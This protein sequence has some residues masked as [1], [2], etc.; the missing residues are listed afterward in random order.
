MFHFTL[1]EVLTKQKNHDPVLFQRRVRANPQQREGV[2]LICPHG[3]LIAHTRPSFPRCFYC[4][5]SVGLPA[6][7]FTLRTGFSTL[8]RWTLRLNNSLLWRAVLG[9]VGC[10]VVSLLSPII[11]TKV[12][13]RPWQICPWGHHHPRLLTIALKETSA[14]IPSPLGNWQ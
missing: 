10:L 14:M 13:L 8:A 1:P 9:N 5:P 2:L 3:F 11:T 4:R 7:S 6:L 12:I